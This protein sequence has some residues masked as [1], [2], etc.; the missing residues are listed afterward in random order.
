MFKRQKKEEKRAEK[1]E[2][3]EKEQTLRRIEKGTSSMAEKKA[4]LMKEI[5]QKRR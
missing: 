3:S 1:K 2:L 5:N 4:K